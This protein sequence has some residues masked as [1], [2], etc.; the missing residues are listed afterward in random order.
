MKTSKCLMGVLLSSVLL[1]GSVFAGNALSQDVKDCI[2]KKGQISVYNEIRSVGEYN[3][4]TNRDCTDCEFDFTPYGSEC[5]DTAWDEFGIDCMTLE[6]NYNWDCSGCNCPG[7]GEAV[8]GDGFCSGDETYETCPSDCNA[9]G[10]CDAGQILDCDGSDECWPESWIGDGFADCQDQ[11]YGADLTCYDCDGGDCPESDPGCGGTAE[12]GDGY[13]NGD[14]TEAS[15]PEDCASSGSCE[16]C[17]F[18][19]SAYGSEC[20][21]TAATEYGLSCAALEGNYGWDC[22]GCNCPLDGGGPPTCE[23]QGLWDCGDGQ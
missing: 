13:C 5:C 4:N 9:P 2:I 7:D 17:E 8:C 18:D 14:E 16:D 11:A 21:D 15:C 10:E 22:S 3:D 20:C 19:W 6:A 1:I 23:D 12:C